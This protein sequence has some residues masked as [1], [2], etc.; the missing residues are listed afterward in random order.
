ME[1]FQMAAFLGILGF[2]VYSFL[3]IGFM[4][5]CFWIGSIFYREI[6]FSN[7]KIQSWLKRSKHPR[8][9]KFSLYFLSIFCIYVI[10]LISQLVIKFAFSLVGMLY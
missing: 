9:F 10:L 3:A 8:L 7:E 2:V 5:V 1:L 6:L 4:I